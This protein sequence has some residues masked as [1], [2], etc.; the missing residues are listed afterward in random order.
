MRIDQPD[1]DDLPHTEWK[2]DECGAGNSCLDGECQ[3]CDGPP[4]PTCELCGEDHDM[5][6]CSHGVQPSWGAA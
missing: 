4:A 2:C 1:M 6:D 3:F 5:L